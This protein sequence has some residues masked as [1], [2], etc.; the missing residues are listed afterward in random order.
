MSRFWYRLSVVLCLISVLMLIAVITLESS[1]RGL[2][3]DF[4]A[5]QPAVNAAMN[6][7]KLNNELATALAQSALANNDQAIISL[8]SENGITIN[9]NQQDKDSN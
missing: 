1:N 9:R 2:Q 8:L 6:I 5:K 4:A 3:S 7:S